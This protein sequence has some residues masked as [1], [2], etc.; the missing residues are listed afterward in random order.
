[1]GVRRKSLT[2][3][4]IRAETV[5]PCGWLGKS[6]RPTVRPVDVTT[7]M[8]VRPYESGISEENF[9]IPPELIRLYR[10]AESNSLPDFSNNWT[11]NV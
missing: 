4:I 2:A 8:C 10:R 5:R 1:M 7:V 9:L 6:L 3:E 11:H